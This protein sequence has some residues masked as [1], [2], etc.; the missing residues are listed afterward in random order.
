[1]VLDN[2]MPED[3]TNLRIGEA[4]VLGRETAYGKSVEGCYEDTFVVKSEI[5]ELRE[6][7]SVPIGN[8]GMNAF[9]QKPT[10]EDK[11]RMK[12]AIISIGR[13]D[14]TV[15]GLYPVDSKVDIVGASSDHLIID[16]TNSD[17]E[18][19]VGDVVEFTVDYGCLLLA[20]TSPYVEKYFVE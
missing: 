8:I 6:K 20:T 14:I 11:G 18:Y 15:D 2:T 19:K 9:G 10:F 17:K 13:Q 3:V 5:I 12:R 7:P 16:V 4:I 1:M